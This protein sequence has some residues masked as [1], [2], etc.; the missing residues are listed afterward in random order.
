MDVCSSQMQKAS[1]KHIVLITRFN[2]P[3]TQCPMP[4]YRRHVINIS[5]PAS[6]TSRDMQ[7]IFAFL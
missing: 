5:I 4:T 2:A 1:E 6:H 7:Y 3:H